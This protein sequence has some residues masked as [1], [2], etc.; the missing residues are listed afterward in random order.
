MSVGGDKLEI[1]TPEEL[2]KKIK[3]PVQTIRKYIWA[4]RMKGTKIGKHRRVTDEQ[5]KGFLDKST[6]TK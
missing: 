2:S 4:G 1:Y 5:L 6:T 3:L